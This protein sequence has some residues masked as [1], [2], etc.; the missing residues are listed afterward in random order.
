[1]PDLIAKIVGGTML[2]ATVIAFLHNPWPILFVVA[3]LLAIAYFIN[4]PI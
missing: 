1:M 3:V 2:L 4:P